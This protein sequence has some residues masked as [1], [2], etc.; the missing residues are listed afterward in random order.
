[1]LLG[2]LFIG[3]Y[4]YDK[5][6]KA[7]SKL[8]KIFFMLFPLVL[9]SIHLLAALALVFLARE[10]MLSRLKMNVFAE[11]EKR[12]R[13]AISLL[14]LVFLALSAGLFFFYPSLRPVLP[15]TTHTWLAYIILP[16]LFYLIAVNL[17]FIKRNKICLAILFLLIIGFFFQ[18]SHYFNE[19]KNYKEMV[20]YVRGN[21]KAEEIFLIPPFED[22]LRI[23]LER[24]VVVDKRYPYTDKALIQWYGRFVDISNNQIKKPD[25]GEFGKAEEGY[26]SLKESD[27]FRLSDKYSFKYALFKKPKE[28]NLPKFFENEEYIV[29][30]LPENRGEKNIYLNSPSFKK[31]LKS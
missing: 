1:M 14:I 11:L 22:R 20:S 19:D 28:L 16:V 9:I 18:F 3:N 25:I 29:Y 24:A 30:L 8:E 31:Q 23:D 2:H 15:K 17:L 12:K 7:K 5:I 4:I 10:F 26:N 21:T 27:L 13:M 6:V